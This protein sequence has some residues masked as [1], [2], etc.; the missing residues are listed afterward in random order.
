[1]SGVLYEVD[2]AVEMAR[3]ARGRADTYRWL[4]AREPERR[5][6]TQEELHHMARECDFFALA[7]ERLASRE[8]K[9]K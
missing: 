9:G 5:T 7:F 6:F 8:E 3:W 4:A 2:N 1:M